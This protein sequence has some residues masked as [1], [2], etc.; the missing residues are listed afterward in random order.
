MRFDPQTSRELALGR[1]TLKGIAKPL[2]KL[3]KVVRNES[4]QGWIN[5]ALQAKIG[6]IHNRR[7]ISKAE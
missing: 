7:S 4:Q 6:T 1:P 2:L 5:R 3:R